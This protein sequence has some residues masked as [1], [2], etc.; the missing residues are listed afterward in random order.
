MPEWMD[1][2]RSLPAH[3]LFS[4]ASGLGVIVLGTILLRFIGR[5]VQA[6]APDGRGMI[7]NTYNSV[8]LPIL[9]GI[10]LGGVRLIL[11][12]LPMGTAPDS[13]RVTT[14]M[15]LQFLVVVFGGEIVFG[16]G[17]DYY[18]R[19]KRG[20]DIPAIFTQLLKAILY[21]IVGLSFLSTTYKIDITPLLTTSAVF[22]AVIGLALQDVLMNLFSGISVHI[23]PPFKI[24]DWIRVGGYTGKVIE[25]NWRA[26]TLLTGLYELVVLPNNDI[27]K[28]DIVNLSRSPGR[29]YVDL[30]IGLAYDTSPEQAR[31]SLLEACKQVNEIY[32][33]PAPR[34]YMEGFGDSAINYRLRYW[35]P[36]LDD[37][38]PIRSKLASRIWYRLK[39]DG[40]TIPFPQ[41][42][43]YIHPEKDLRDQVMAH[44]LALLSGVDFFTGLDRTL[45]AFL[46]ESLR[47]LV[48][49][50][51]EIIFAK[52]SMGTDFYIIDQ[53]SVTVHLDDGMG[54][55]VASLSPGAFFGEMSLLTGE[56]R[57]ATLRATTET[58]LLVMCRES[59][60]RAL[61]ENEDLARI[62]SEAVTQR[63]MANQTR[64]SDSE[65][66]S[67]AASEITRARNESREAS[68]QLLDRI[69]R[70][71]RLR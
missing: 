17:A 29:F 12:T 19:E 45:K 58:R 3:W 57:S 22:T 18:L 46:A 71:F 65:T 28:K 42:E 35:I 6:T 64:E 15:L 26:T 70:F 31:Q 9:L 25:S 49:E 69:R 48:F 53:G 34:V 59:L 51:G 16:L 13:W 54:A 60:G 40:F 67:R 38:A 32:K 50:S 4:V 2:N 43:V 23:A 10:L 30:P 27:A 52:N 66:E 33:D 61:E 14:E 5:R 7:A 24:G 8:Y 36:D 37:N 21:T 39:R 55:P 11:G 1:L 41:R 47:E 56:P 68:S 20:T 63:R 62:L 44:R